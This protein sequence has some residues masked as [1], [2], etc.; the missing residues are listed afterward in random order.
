MNQLAEDF[1]EHGYRL[2]HTLKRIANS[3]AYA[4]SAI[5]IPGN[6]ADDRYYS[7]ALRKPL[8]PE[9]LADAISDVLG[10]ADT[11]GSQPF[12]TRAVALFD[13]SIKSDALD[14]LE[15]KSF[16]N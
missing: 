14:I 16:R 11:Y 1:V 13:A 3:A 7:H 10:V 9:V 8:E 12:G 2:R 15:Q 5:T 6:A 4:R